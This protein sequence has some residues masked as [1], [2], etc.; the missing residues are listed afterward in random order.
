MVL[1]SSAR[2]QHDSPTAHRPRQFGTSGFR[3][4][5]G[6]VVV[7]LIGA[8][9]SLAVLVHEGR[10]LPLD[11]RIALVVLG[12]SRGLRRI[13]GLLGRVGEAP[14]WDTACLAVGLGLWCT[15]ARTTGLLLPVAVVVAEMSTIA[16]KVVVGYVPIALDELPSYLEVDSFPSGHVA[17]VVV[18]LGL[19]GIGV[20]R[21]AAQRRVAIVVATLGGLLMGW[22]RIV[23]HS[24]S[25]SDDLGAIL[26]AFIVVGLVGLA[27][28]RISADSDDQSKG[29]PT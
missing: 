10:L 15:R 6:L 25:P 29:R 3:L 17:R 1:F 14:V 20:A 8:L 4:T 28:Q 22:A 5:S 13:A 27:R 7:G 18:A 19:V 2:Q 21:S 9:A 12:A 23:T 11:E 16:L 24:H 26:L